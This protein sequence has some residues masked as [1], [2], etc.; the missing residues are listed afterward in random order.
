TKLEVSVPLSAKDGELVLSTHSGKTA[1]GAVTL[2][3]PTVSGL[4][5]TNLIAGNELTITGTH[6]DLVRQV[7]F[8]GA[9]V[10][11]DVQA[12]SATTLRVQVPMS[13][14]SGV[15]TLVTANGTE[16]K[17]SM[18]LVVTS[19]NIPVITKIST[20]AKPGELIRIEGTKL[21][22]VESVYFQDNV[23]GTQYGMRNESLIE[24]YI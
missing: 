23:K 10:V 19:P 6:L 18:S 2:V 24:V 15:I 22:L 21:H 4:S 20:S 5:P 7:I 14:E 16:V 8:G 13:A 9:H 12:T 3:R 17:S 1:T 11:D